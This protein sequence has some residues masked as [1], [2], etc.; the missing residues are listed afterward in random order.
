MY[1]DRGRT[2]KC[3]PHFSLKNSP[4]FEIGG[5]IKLLKYVPCPPIFIAIVG[6]IKECTGL[7]QWLIIPNVYVALRY[8][9]NVLEPQ[10]NN[11]YAE[12]PLTIGDL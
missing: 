9:K 12:C 6:R 4:I 7:K 3:T 2:A 1:V 10:I 8:Q 5:L 11:L